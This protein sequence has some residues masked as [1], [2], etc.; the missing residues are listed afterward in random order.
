MSLRTSSELFCKTYTAM[1]DLASPAV[2]PSCSLSLQGLCHA[3]PSCSLP[4]YFGNSWW[5][6]RFHLQH[7][8]LKVSSDRKIIFDHSISSPGPHMPPPSSTCH[9]CNFVF[10]LSP[11][12]PLGSVRWGTVA[13]FA[14]YFISRPC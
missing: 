11:S 6:C 13:G 7:H 10:L 14:H 1:P 9:I 3:V 8:C 5:S 2:P 12:W 4:L